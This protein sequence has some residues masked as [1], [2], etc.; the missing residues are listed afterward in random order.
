MHIC[1]KIETRT[2]HDRSLCD[3]DQF[4]KRHYA[5]NST[6]THIRISCNIAGVFNI[7]DVILFETE[8]V[9]PFIYYSR[10]RIA[11]GLKVII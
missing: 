6:C 10:E 9:E 3:V 5:S 11:A 1:I 8:I 4:I 2:A 7:S